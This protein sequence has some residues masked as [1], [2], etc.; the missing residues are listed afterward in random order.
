M[1]L[2]RL[3]CW[4]VVV[5]FSASMGCSQPST[6]LAEYN[7]TNVERIRTM[8]SMY[9]SSHSMRGPK[10]KD[11][12][13]KFITSNARAKV[14]MGRV[15]LNPNE[16]DNYFIGMRDDEPIVVRWGLNS[17]ADHAIAFEKTGVNGKRMVAFGNVRELDKEEY[18]GYLDGSIKPEAPP[19]GEYEPTEEELLEVLE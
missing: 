3:T 1:K 16:F 8:Y 17:L 7:D 18:E 6:D 11:E 10:D 15:G 5:V 13:K 19:S 9:L 14:L 2:T 4:V 12:L